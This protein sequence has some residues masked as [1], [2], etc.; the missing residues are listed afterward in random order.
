LKGETSKTEDCEKA[1]AALLDGIAALTKHPYMGGSWSDPQAMKLDGRMVEQTMRLRLAICHYFTAKVHMARQRHDEVTRSLVRAASTAGR[2]VGEH[3]ALHGHL[4][5]LLGDLCLA[6]HQIQ[7]SANPKESPASPIASAMELPA[8]MNSE[9][10]DADT[11]PRSIF[12]AV[13]LLDA[14]IGGA[15]QGLFWLKTG[16]GHYNVAWD[17]LKGTATEH[18]CALRV[19]NVYNELGQCHLRAGEYPDAGAAFESGLRAFEA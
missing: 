12:G 9:W 3:P 13:R 4:F 1:M 14:Y 15:D 5:V 11:N 19:G 6:R 7:G 17:L 10:E 2:T 16:V 18:R 8:L